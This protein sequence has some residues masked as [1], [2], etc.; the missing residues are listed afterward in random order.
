MRLTELVDETSVGDDRARDLG[1]ETVHAGGKTGDH[2]EQDCLKQLNEQSRPS[3]YAVTHL[4]VL[5]GGLFPT[6]LRENR[7]SGGALD[8]LL[9]VD[10]LLRV[11]L[12]ESM[13]LLGGS[14]GPDSGERGGHFVE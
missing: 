9:K 4:P 6:E 12:L 11:G 2:A 1:L 3:R 8:K 14:D 5:L 13:F 7:G 10:R